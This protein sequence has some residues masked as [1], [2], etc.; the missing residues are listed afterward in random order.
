MYRIL[1]IEDDAIIRQT[2]DKILRPENYELFFSFN[3]SDGL[4]SCL[5][6]KPDIILLDVNLPDANGIDFCRKI[7]IEEKIRHIP[8]L[9][10][11][12]EAV[13][14]ERR[15]EGL[16]AGADDYILKPFDYKELVF[17]IKR[18]LKQI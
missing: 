7:K 13:D 9:I 14:V 15:M 11:T 12:G 10:V 17:R 8:V 3:A 1:I 4:A 2:L 6:H 18:I 16:E 5:R